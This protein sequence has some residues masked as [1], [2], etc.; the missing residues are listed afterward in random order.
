MPKASGR[1]QQFDDL[2]LVVDVRRRAAR[3]RPEDGLIWYFRGWLELAQ[4]TGER[5]QHPQLARRGGTVAVPAL[6]LSCPGGHQIDRQRP[7]VAN[8]GD[9]A[10]EARQTVTH[11]AE[12]KARTPPLSQ[13]LLDP[14]LQGNVRAHWVLPGHGS[15]TPANA[16]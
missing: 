11:G 5:A 13:V 7:V 1:G 3:N 4:P 16:P 8:L 6:G 14:G 15:A 12:L 9:V 10:G 2:V